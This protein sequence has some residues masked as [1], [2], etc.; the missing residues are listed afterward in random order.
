MYL[1]MYSSVLVIVV[2]VSHFTK[3]RKWCKIKKKWMYQKR[4]LTFPLNKKVFELCLENYIFRSSHFLAGIIFKTLQLWRN[5]MCF[6]WKA[7]ILFWFTGLTC[8]IFGLT[9]SCMPPWDN[10][11]IFDCMTLVI[12]FWLSCW[13][14]SKL[15]NVKHLVSM[16]KFCLKFR[17]ITQ[18]DGINKFTCT[19][20]LLNT[21]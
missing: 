6:S 13:T 20:V 14:S 7:K 21:E 11:F 10:F 18:H 17:N 15:W 3:S 9:L 1:K 2:M 16:K 5:A 4:N 8:V 19:G 12:S